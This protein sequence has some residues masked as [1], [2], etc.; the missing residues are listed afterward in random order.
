[1]SKI[2]EVDLQ[3]QVENASLGTHRDRQEACKA[4]QGDGMWPRGQKPSTTLLI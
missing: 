1:M 3:S 2:Q 4:S